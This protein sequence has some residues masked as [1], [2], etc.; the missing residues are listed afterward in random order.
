MSLLASLFG[1]QAPA[2]TNAPT[3]GPAAPATAPAQQQQQPQQ[4]QEAPT[5]DIPIGAAADP[6][7][8]AQQQQEAP[9]GTAALMELFQQQGSGAEPEQAPSLNL[10]P[11]ILQEATKD[12]NFMRGI[13]E[14]MVKQV[15]EGDT[16]ALLGIIQ[17]VA[18]NSY[19][20][21]MLDGSSLAGQYAG[22][23]ADYAAS[24]AAR[25]IRGQVI[26]S[27]VDVES[28]SPAAQGMFREIAGRVAE[29]NPTANAKEVQAQ[30]TAILQ[31]M[32]QEFNF[33]GNQQQAQK[34]VE[35]DW[36]K[37]FN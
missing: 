28:L 21:A 6:T 8:Q 30:A 18:R 7:A 5:G 35:D 2:P 23:R 33:K 16:N 11:E 31:Q 37:V 26:E 12:M 25:G 36:S 4:Q 17:T 22:A 19:E 20:S 15:Q 34:P 27:Q 32:A 9:E 1:G 3:S 14:D 29:R 13:S 24:Q 10:T